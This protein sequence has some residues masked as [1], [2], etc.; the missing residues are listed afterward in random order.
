MLN[1]ELFIKNMTGLC[2]IFEREATEALLDIYYSAMSELSDE[3]FKQGIASVV[4]GKKFNKLP[5][6]GDIVDACSGGQSV[7]L[8]ALN[9]AEHAIEKHGSYTSVVFDD[10]VIH[11]V[12][13]AMGGWPKFC[14][15]SAYGDDQEWHWKQKEFIALYETFSKNPRANCPLQ[16]S[17]ISDTQNAADGRFEKFIS[18]PV[19][20]GDERKVI[21]WQA[22]HKKELEGGVA[23]LIAQI[24]VK[25]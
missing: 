12:V 5:L 16:L 23:A 6:P 4:R 15:P 17:G 18:R 13:S 11:M 22:N 9:K 10:P 1:R 7:A 8:L 2:E 3:Q 20:I 25:S 14:C 19:I 24:A 21:E